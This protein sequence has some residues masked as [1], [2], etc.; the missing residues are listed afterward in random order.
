MGKIQILI[1]D[2]HPIIRAGL[3]QII[4]ETNDM[5]IADEAGNGQEVLNLVRK[6]K[7]DLLLLDISMPGR[8]GLEILKELKSEYPK[9]PVLILSIYPEEQYAVRAFR[10]GASGY[11]TKES[12][13][14]ELISAIYKIVKGGRY[15]SESLAEELTYYLDK[16]ASRPLH[17]LLTDREYQV[18]L[19]LGSGRTVKEAAEELHLSVKTISTYRTH[20]LEKMNMKNNAELT[21]YVVKNNLVK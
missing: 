16:D 6:K 2:D 10:A 15:V 11:L 4:S 8:N 21:L 3:K 12:A 19:L 1:A 14:N 18:M 9:L 20:I 5:T 13:A 7:Y 17:D